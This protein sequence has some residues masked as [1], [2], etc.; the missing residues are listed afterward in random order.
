MQRPG[1]PFA[2]GGA[3][4]IPR[5]L[6][7]VPTASEPQRLPPERPDCRELAAHALLSPQALSVGIFP[8]VLKLLQSSAR[9]LRPLLVFIW[10][11][12]LAVDSVSSRVL[13]AGA[14]WPPHVSQPGLGRSAESG[15]PGGAGCTGLPA[16]TPCP[17]PVA[18]PRLLSSLH[19]S[20]C[21]RSH[22]PPAASPGTAGPPASRISEVHPLGAWARS[23]ELH[24]HRLCY[25]PCCLFPARPAF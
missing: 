16:R 10:A 11:K 24:T 5:A 9:E 6:K 20:L 17:H 12:I 25:I 1:G 22:C 13:P 8:Y 21:L 14:R 15:A 19:P 23:P 7:A 18:T 4:A 3:H 2:A